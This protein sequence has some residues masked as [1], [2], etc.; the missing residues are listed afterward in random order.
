MTDLEAAYRLGDDSLG[1]REDKERWAA[2]VK[3][4]SRGGGLQSN[5]A[6]RV[7]F[8]VSTSVVEAD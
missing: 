8:E 6:I 7:D 5:V 4:Q 3:L 2:I 1:R